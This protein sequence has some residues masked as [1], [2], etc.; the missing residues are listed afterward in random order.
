MLWVRY[1][2]NPRHG[3]F[4]G[5]RGALGAATVPPPRGGRLSMLTFAHQPNTPHRA[6]LSKW[7][8]AAS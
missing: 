5:R 1:P 4:V 3:P 7:G 6:A 2:I 8:E